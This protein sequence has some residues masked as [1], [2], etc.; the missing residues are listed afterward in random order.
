[1]PS[2]GKRVI[3]TRKVTDPQLSLLMRKIDEAMAL[4]FVG[5]GSPQ[6]VV[7]APIGAIFQR[8]DGGAATTLYVKE[9]GTGNTGWVAK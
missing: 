2:G 7:V 3:E 5:K 4:R 6:G 8:T 1:M 9:S